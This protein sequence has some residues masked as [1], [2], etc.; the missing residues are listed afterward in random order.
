MDGDSPQ[1]HRQQQPETESRPR[2]CFLPLSIVICG[3][4]PAIEYV[5]YFSLG[6]QYE[7]RYEL[8]W[9]MARGGIVCMIPG[10]EQRS[11]TVMLKGGIAGAIVRVMVA[12]V[13]GLLCIWNT[14]A[15]YNPAVLDNLPPH[16]PTSSNGTLL[17]DPWPLVFGYCIWMVAFTYV[18]AV[19]WKV[20]SVGRVLCLS[21]IFAAAMAILLVTVTPWHSKFEFEPVTAVP[22]PPL[23][24]TVRIVFCSIVPLCFIWLRILIRYESAVQRVRCPFAGFIDR[25]RQLWWFDDE[26]GGN[27]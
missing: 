2:S 10:I 17:A 24:L 14:R 1:K 20:A 12:I 25:L 22:Y 18:W 4:L 15:G 16:I 7:Y 6:I 9:L 8:A 21:A 13:T 11:A 23:S 19:L 26:P 3:V 5:D 27:E